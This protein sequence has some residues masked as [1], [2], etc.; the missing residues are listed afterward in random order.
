[1][2]KFLFI[3]VLFFVLYTLNSV[4]IQREFTMYEYSVSIKPTIVPDEYWELIEWNCWINDV[5]VYFYVS[6][7]QLE[8]NF[9]PNAKGYNIQSDTWDLGICQFNDRYIPLFSEQFNGGILFDPFN[10][11][12]AIPVS[13]KLLKSLY[14]ELGSWDKAAMGYNC[15]P[16]RVKIN[17]IPESTLHYFKKVQSNLDKIYDS[18]VQYWWEG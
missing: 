6:M 15:G 11:E 18:I 14:R 13:I 7:L 8:S 12:E 2:K 10:P 1:M 16:Y 3:F 9:N 4:Q 5:P 17:R